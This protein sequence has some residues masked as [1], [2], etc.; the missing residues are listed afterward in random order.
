[1]GRLILI[2]SVIFCISC[3]GGK[4]I[5]D[6]KNVEELS[7]E[8]TIRK[9]KS[10][11]VTFDHFNS[12]ADLFIK[13]EMFTGSVNAKFRMIKDSVIWIAANKLGFE[14]G[15]VLITQDSVFMMERLQR[16]YVK[17]SFDELSEMAGMQLDF[18]FVQDFLMGNPYLGETSNEVTYFASDSLLIKPALYDLKIAHNIDL[19][20]YKLTSTSIRDDETKMDATLHYSDYKEIEENQLFSYIRDIL[21]D[22]GSS[23]KREISIKFNNPEINVEK[24]IKFSI[25]DTYTAREF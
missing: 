20:N 15:R 4:K 16:T 21:L 19:S 13:T 10:T 18:N 9:V 1:M 7:E 25:P 2:I 24:N 6:N 23:E 14:V 11:F 3:T 5:V 22:D 8:A 17:A 12:N